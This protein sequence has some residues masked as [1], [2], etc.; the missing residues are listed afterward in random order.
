MSTCDSRVIL[1]PHLQT[2]FLVLLYSLYS[3]NHDVSISALNTFPS[4]LFQTQ[5]TNLSV[6]LLQFLMM[7]PRLAIL[8]V[9]LLVSYAHGHDDD[10]AHDHTDHVQDLAQKEEEVAQN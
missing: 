4:C 8:I 2:H 7:R 1:F 6:R 3:F 5:G 9:A 10:A